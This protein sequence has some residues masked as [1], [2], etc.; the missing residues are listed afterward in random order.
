[1]KTLLIPMSEATQRLEQA[2]QLVFETSA[3]EY[4]QFC[5]TFSSLGG[6][7]RAWVVKGES[8]TGKTYLANLLC[9]KYG[10]DRVVTVTVGNLAIMY[11]G[12]LLKGLTT[13]LES[14]RLCSKTV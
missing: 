5:S 9:K 7:P 8:G 11:P 3:Q 10:V 12:D 2:F 13:Y 1:M 14:T 4:A 6:L